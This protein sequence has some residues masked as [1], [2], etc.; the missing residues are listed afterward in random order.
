MYFLNHNIQTRL[1]LCRVGIFSAAYWLKSILTVGIE[2]A[3]SNLNSCFRH[4]AFFTA[5]SRVRSSDKSPS[6]RDLLRPS[7]NQRKFQVPNR[8][9]RTMLPFLTRARVM[10]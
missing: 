5:A 8:L 6:F 4:S 3:G 2:N 9:F 7:S 1:V 10:K